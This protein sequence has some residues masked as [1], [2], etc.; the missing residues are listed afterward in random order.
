MKRLFVPRMEFMDPTAEKLPRSRLAA[1]LLLA[2]LGCALDLGTKS[3]TFARMGYDPPDQRKVIKLWPGI[4]ELETHLNEGALFGIGQGRGNMFALLSIVAAAGILY[5]LFYLKA[6]HD[7][8]LTIALGA[9]TAGIF[10]NLYDRLGLHGL[11]WRRVGQLHEQGEPIKAVRDWIHFQTPWFDW[12][13]FNIADT[14]LVCGAGL[15]LWH[16][17]RGETA[18]AAASQT[19]PA[20]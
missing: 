19:Q 2:V 5:W 12:P 13:I 1:F 10:G 16:A 6:A 14:L 4:L 20:K 17:F 3:W 7:W 11:V 8:L 9:I 18:P 15:L